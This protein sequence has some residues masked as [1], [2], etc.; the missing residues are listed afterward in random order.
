MKYFDI[1]MKSMKTQFKINI[2]LDFWTIG[3][4]LALSL[5]SI[6]F[7]YS[8][9]FHVPLAQKPFI[10]KFVKQI[11]FLVIGLI[12]YFAIANIN[13]QNLIAK[14][15]FVYGLGVFF[16]LLT[17][18]IG[19][20]VNNSKSWIKI[21]FISLQL[22]EF[23]KILFLLSFSVFLNNYHH[24]IKKLSFLM[25]S[26]FLL[27]PYL[28]LLFLQPDIGTS[29]IFLIIFFAMLFVSGSN[30]LYLGIILGTGIIA[31]FIPFFTYYFVKMTPTESS[32][33]SFFNNPGLVTL[34]GFIFLA[35]S[36]IFYFIHRYI[37]LSKK[38]FY[39]FLILL[40]VGAGFLFT[41][42]VK[43]LFKDYHYE[44]FLVFLNPDTD[45]Y[46]KGY[47]IQQSLISIGSGQLAGQGFTKGNQNRGNFLPSEDTDFIISLIGEEWGFIGIALIIFLYILLIY[48][49]L[50]IAYSARDFVSSLIALGITSMYMGHIMINIFSAIGFFPVVGVPLP[51]ISYGGSSLLANYI[52]LGV[53]FSIKIRRFS[54]E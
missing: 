38:V 2:K 3:I 49:C 40:T 26:F 31:I 4:A 11:I 51:F 14:P 15:I 45:R 48:R 18:L 43:L 1:R 6:L 35:A 46:G 27:A 53:L 20:K 50:Y 21:G 44:R 33:I 34:L 41:N 12:V 17:L 36:G 24:I 42:A 25:I 52:G 5:I 30:A 54:Y 37:A 22:S 19:T 16:L 7:I 28:G 23:S 13:Y 9:S 8:S 32:V 10:E 39:L 29:I 47:N